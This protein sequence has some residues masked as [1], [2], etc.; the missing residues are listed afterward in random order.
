MLY[1]SLF[2]RATI[3]RKWPR[4][5][6]RKPKS[7]YLNIDEYLRNIHFLG[8]K[9]PFLGTKSGQDHTVNI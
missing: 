7:E 4:Y 1:Q 5:V 3:A 8:R 2:Y 9:R 6:W